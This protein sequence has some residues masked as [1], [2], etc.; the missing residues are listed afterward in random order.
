M[1]N[2][3]VLDKL[4]YI[5]R[6][7]DYLELMNK[8]L[9]GENSIVFTSY[10]DALIRKVRNYKYI[11]SAL[12]HFLYWKKSYSYAK[13]ILKCDY[14]NIYCINPIVGIFLG[15]KNKRSR[16]ILAGFLFEPKKNKMYYKLRKIFARMSLAGVQKA[17]VYG[18]NEEKY[19]EA[20]F[21]NVTQFKFL[22]YGIDFDNST[23]YVAK[24]IPKDYLFSGGGSNRDYQTLVNAYNKS[25]ASLPLVIATQ[26]WRLEGLDIS[27]VEILDDVVVENFGD[28]LKKSRALILSLKESNLSAG[29]MVMLQ[30]MSLGVPIIVNDIPAIRDYVDENCVKFYKSQDIDELAQII[31]YFDYECFNKKVVL[32][33]EKY[34]KELTFMG[35]LSR[36][37]RE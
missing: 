37:L 14:D 10:E 23:E 12:Q 32:A 29:H 22:E 25:N 35:L 31:N 15:L 13:E 19:Y 18:K 17:I 7:H 9:V 34:N 28:V 24:S 30:A 33:K 2:L 21:G 1:K 20:L 3:L 27:K 5:E 11:G 8:Q 26:P 6:E 36:I 16:L 4:E